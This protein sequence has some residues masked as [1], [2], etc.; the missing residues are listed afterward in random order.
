MGVSAETQMGQGPWCRA[1]K[2]QTRHRHH[3]PSPAQKE[4]RLWEGGSPREGRVGPGAAGWSIVG[5]ED[6]I[7]PPAGETG[8]LGFQPPP[9]DLI[10]Q[11]HAQTPIE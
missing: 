9:G 10:K 6:L 5:G 11:L 3:T 7:L 1:P 4:T 8:K 2:I